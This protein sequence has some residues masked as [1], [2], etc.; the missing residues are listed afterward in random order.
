MLKFKQSKNYPGITRV[1]TPEG[2]TCAF[3]GTAQILLD[4]NLILV[5]PNIKGQPD[6][7]LLVVCWY[8]AYLNDWLVR[9][10]FDNEDDVKQYLIDKFKGEN[11]H[12]SNRSKN[13]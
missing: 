2:F 3:Y 6:T 9:H 5:N 7:N 10:D 11:K 13:R 1:K 12:E 8:D 4:A